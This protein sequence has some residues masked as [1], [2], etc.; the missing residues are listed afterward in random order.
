MYRTIF[1]AE[2]KLWSGV[3]MP[4]VYTDP[5]ISLGHVLLRAMK[6]NPTKVAQVLKHIVSVLRSVFSLQYSDNF[7]SVQIVD[8][9]S[10]MKNFT[11]KR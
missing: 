7:R 8:S 9:N 11:R 3:D 5:T 4:P 2:E 10:R 1:D 6:L